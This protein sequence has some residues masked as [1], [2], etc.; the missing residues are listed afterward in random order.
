VLFF[1]NNSKGIGTGTVL[2]APAHSILIVDSDTAL[3]EHLKKL[4]AGMGFHVLGTACDG[5][6]ALRMAEEEHPD[7]VLMEIVL[8]GDFGGLAACE[9][10]QK[11]LSIPVVLMTGHG[12]IGYK[13][14][15]EEVEPAGFLFKPSLNKQITGLLKKALSAKMEAG[16]QESRLK[17]SYTRR[18]LERRSESLTVK[19]P[20]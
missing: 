6:Q 2:K 11:K 5:K 18:M 9:R 1:V 17:E 8:P 14:A 12:N 4:L 15:A 3:I 13:Y 10:I 19:E 7:V 16:Q 20:A